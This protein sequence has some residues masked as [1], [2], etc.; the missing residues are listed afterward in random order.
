M[1]YSYEIIFSK[2]LCQDMQSDQYKIP[3]KEPICQVVTDHN[4]LAGVS[5]NVIDFFSLCISKRTSLKKQLM[6]IYQDVHQE[7]QV[8]RPL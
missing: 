2:I 8:K 7:V 4:N 6:V 1:A 3:I 5:Y